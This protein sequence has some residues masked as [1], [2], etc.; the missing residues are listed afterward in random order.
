MDDEGLTQAQQQAL[1]E[2]LHALQGEL[3][4]LVADEAGLADTVVLDQSAVGRISRID[5]I[6]Q[7]ATAKATLRRHRQR[8]ERVEAALERMAQD[9]EE[10]GWCPDCEEF[11]GW[12]RLQAIPDAVLCVA[13]QTGRGL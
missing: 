3:A 4:R 1:S 5:A 11:I 12:R 9:P 7:Q 10:F 2:A 8:M 6:Q 13:C